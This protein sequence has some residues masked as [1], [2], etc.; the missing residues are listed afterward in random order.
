MGSRSQGAARRDVSASASAAG[1]SCW[2]CRAFR[3]S[4]PAGS[5]LH[6]SGVLGTSEGSAQLELGRIRGELYVGLGGADAVHPPQAFAPARAELE[7]HGIRYLA[8][9]HEGAAHGYM[10]PG[11]PVYHEQAC[12]RSWERTFDLFRR[13]LQ[14]APVTA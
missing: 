8:E 9:V 6:P 4:S 7:R 2:R 14:E 10:I 1:L 13:T 5:A 12:E 11:T 3:T